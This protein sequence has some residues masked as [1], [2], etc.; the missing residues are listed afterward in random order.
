MSKLISE[1]VSGNLHQACEYVNKGKLADHVIHM[2]C[3]NGLTSII[4]F[5]VPDDFDMQ[6]HWDRL[7]PRPKPP[8]TCP[9]HVFYK[10]GCPTCEAIVRTENPE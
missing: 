10:S 2:D 5:R 7:Y 3:V 4:V 8:A 9:I 1:T 6:A